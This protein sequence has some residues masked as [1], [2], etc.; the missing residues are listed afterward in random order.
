[1]I[2]VSGMKV[3]PN[4]VEEVLSSHPKIAEAA[5]IGLPDRHSGECVVA[6]IV[7]RDAHLNIEE[8]RQFCRE[9]LTSY[10]LPRRIEFRETLP[11]SNVG[12][13]LR[14]ALRDE[15]SGASTKS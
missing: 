10:K 3:F 12:K 8:I 2:V 9:R 14:R 7:R 11:K 4:E 6:Y 13:I 5:V 1:M 15:A